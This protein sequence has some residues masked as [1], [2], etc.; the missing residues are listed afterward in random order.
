MSYLDMVD[1]RDIY[2][3]LKSFEERL[4]KLEGKT[5]DDSVLQVSDLTDDIGIMQAGE[6]RTGTGEPGEGFSGVRIASPAMDYDV[7]GVTKQFN[8]VGVRDDVLQFGLDASSGAAIAGGGAVKIDEDGVEITAI[9]DSAGWE[10]P[11][12]YSF[13]TPSIDNVSD[14]GSMGGVLAFAMDDDSER[15]IKLRCLNLGNFSGDA[16]SNIELIAESKEEYWVK[17]LL[18]TGFSSAEAGMSVWSNLGPVFFL[19]SGDLSLDYG[20]LVNTTPPG[21]RIYRNSTQAITGSQWNYLSWNTELHDT[22]GCWSSGDGSKMYAK[23]AGYYMA[24]GGFAVACTAYIGIFLN[25]ATMSM[26]GQVAAS[27]FD[28]TTGMFYMNVDDY[29]QI[30]VNPT[31]NVT[32]AA[33]GATTK[34]AN[35]GWLA[36]IA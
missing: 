36:R 26:N 10:V 4:I 8:I 15:A 12:A 16:S 34:Y 18:S 9:H 28:I 35:H 27:R 5:I 23:S 31:A 3:L 24:G 29:V 7:G 13:A 20:K 25:G 2:Q 17:L 30:G 6:F 19:F 33:A 22:D 11:H 1:G 14:G 32:V 21:C